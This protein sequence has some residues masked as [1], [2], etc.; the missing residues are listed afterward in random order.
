MQQQRSIRSPSLIHSQ[1]TIGNKF[2][3][4]RRYDLLTNLLY[5]IKWL[6]W[7]HRDTLFIEALHTCTGN[8][9]SFF[10]YIF[11]KIISVFLD[12]IFFFFV[13]F[14]LFFSFYFIFFFCRRSRRRCCI[15]V[16]VVVVINITRNTAF[17]S[18][19]QAK[20]C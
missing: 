8:V 14:N 9:N 12:L 11:Y 13:S 15:N 6:I 7:A 18:R 1:S 20:P 4:V 19:S 10:V 3:T 5:G 17:Q 2:K 16:V